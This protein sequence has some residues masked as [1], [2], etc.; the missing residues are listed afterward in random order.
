MHT[1]VWKPLTYIQIASFLPNK[2]STN[3]YSHQHFPNSVACS[4]P[5]FAH[6][7]YT[8]THIHGVAPKACRHTIG[9]IQDLPSLASGLYFRVIALCIQIARGTEEQVALREAAG[10]RC[11]GWKNN[12]SPL[13]GPHFTPGKTSQFKSWAVV[14]V[15]CGVDG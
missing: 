7:T 14:A 1:R 4:S 9:G 2:C 12:L 13:P 15:V 6:P 5:Y 10:S 8:N 11:S 3:F